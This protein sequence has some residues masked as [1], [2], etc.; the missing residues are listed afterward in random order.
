MFCSQNESLALAIPLPSG[1][2]HDVPLVPLLGTLVGALVMAL[3]ELLMELLTLVG[4]KHE[5]VTVVVTVIKL[6]TTL[7]LML[8]VVLMGA[9]LVAL[10]VEARQELGIAKDKEMPDARE[11]NVSARER[12]LS[13]NESGRITEMV[14]G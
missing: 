2:K 12:M 11:M 9:L 14:E 10:L 13:S 5:P 6:V 1:A 7:L 8:L 4:T 3:T